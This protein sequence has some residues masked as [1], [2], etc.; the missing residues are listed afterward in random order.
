MSAVA[1]LC[2]GYNNTVDLLELCGGKGNIS[3]VAFKRGLVSGGSLDL[4]T[5]YDLGN[6]KVQHAVLHYLRIWNVLVTI[7][8]TNCRSV[9]N[10]SYFSEKVNPDTWRTST[11]TNHTYASVHK[12][13][14]Y[15]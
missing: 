15:R 11:R 12:L 3:K 4:A 5:Y 8:Q 7:L 1:D 10:L 13:P 6:R 14:S 9:G 2:Y